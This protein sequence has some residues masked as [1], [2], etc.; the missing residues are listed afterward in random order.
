MKDIEVLQK[1]LDKAKKDGFV[2]F[3][4]E[5]KAEEKDGEAGFYEGRQFYNFSNM[6]TLT[7]IKKAIWGTGMVKLGDDKEILAMLYYSGQATQKENP[8]EYIATFLK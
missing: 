6:M 5:L 4:S 7:G 8:W 1:V 2:F 3:Q